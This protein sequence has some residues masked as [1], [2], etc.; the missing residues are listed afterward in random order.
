MDLLYH[1]S[2][3]L[4]SKEYVIN[5]VE[6]GGIEPQSHAPDILQCPT[7]HLAVY[8]G[9]YPD[10]TVTPH[11]IYYY[12]TCCVL[13]QV[14]I[15]LMREVGFEPTVPALL[16]SL[17]TGLPKGAGIEPA[18]PDR[19]RLYQLDYSLTDIFIIAHWL[20]DVKLRFC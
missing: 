20:L 17:P 19:G 16:A 10:A 12:N 7:N 5:L 15:L 13:C 2:F 18:V 4:S 11:D 6:S 1:T 9:G 14:K 3:A 8:L